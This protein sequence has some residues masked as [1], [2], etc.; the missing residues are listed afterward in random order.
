MKLTS[1]AVYSYFFSLTNHPYLSCSGREV[2]VVVVVI[3]FTVDVY[4][5]VDIVS[6]C[7]VEGFI[8]S[9]V[10]GSIKEKLQNIT[11]APCGKHR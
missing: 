2:D 8:L 4:S 5:F 3:G 11:E 1:I 7:E 6:M 10:G 9:E